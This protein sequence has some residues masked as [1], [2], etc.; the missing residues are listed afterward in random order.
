MD[1]EH[2]SRL[3]AKLFAQFSSLPTSPALAFY[4]G[5]LVASSILPPPPKA[6]ACAAHK[7]YQHPT[8]GTA[9]SEPTSP[10]RSSPSTQPTSPE[11]AATLDATVL[12]L[13]LA[14]VR[15]S[16]GREE[17][18]FQ[19]SHYASSS[20]EHLDE[21]F[22][23]ERQMRDRMEARIEMGGFE[24]GQR[25]A[26][27]VDPG[28]EE[29]EEALSNDAYDDEEEEEASEDAHSIS[30]SPALPILPPTPSLS[31]EPLRPTRLFAPFLAPFVP[32]TLSSPADPIDT[33]KGGA[34]RAAVFKKRVVPELVLAEGSSSSKSSTRD[35]SV[36]EESE[37]GGEE[38]EE[39]L[40]E[41]EDGRLEEM[42]RDAVRKQRRK[43]NRAE[44]EKGVEREVDDVR[45][46]GRNAKR[47]ARS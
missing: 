13:H 35:E 10:S 39:E 7:S 42:E 5:L 18:V 31:T 1:D 3:T 14:A 12:E 38:E 37:D 32:A 36:E 45:A 24:R 47:K 15:K 27:E 25:A 8:S 43:R 2:T 40:G 29:E 26:A 19:F 30:C 23:F 44:V 21:V 20:S 33:R 41:V 46:G 22:R 28:E 9:P 4:A 34:S 16:F 17:A 11:A 6:T